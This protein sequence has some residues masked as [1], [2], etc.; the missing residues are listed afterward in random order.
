MPGGTSG[1]RDAKGPQKPAFTPVAPGS[2]ASAAIILLTD[3]RRTIGPDALDAAR[4]AAERGVRVFTVGF[5]TAGGAPAE[6]D[7]YSIYMRFD[8]EV[9]KGIAGITKAEYFHAASAADLKRVYAELNAKYVL[10]SRKTEIS[11]LLAAMA[12]IFALVAGTL[13]V[14]WFGRL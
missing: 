8:E 14:L 4:M 12:A 6:I 9:L 13:S 2:N 7:G 3:G 11:A 5:G 10:E 1:S